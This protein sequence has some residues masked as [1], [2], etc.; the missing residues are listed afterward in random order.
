MKRFVFLLGLL[1]LGGCATTGSPEPEIVTQR[2]VVEV[3]VSCVPD[4]LPQ[5][6]TYPDTDK[7]LAEAPNFAARYNL[8][9]VG[10][11]IRVARQAQTEPV[12]RKCR[13]ASGE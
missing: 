12:I 4:N 13:E 7:A 5:E 10:R 9:R 11:G 2:V 8:L 6:P 3:P 1:A